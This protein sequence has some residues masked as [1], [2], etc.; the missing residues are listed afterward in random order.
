MGEVALTP[1]GQVLPNNSLPWLINMSIPNTSSTIA[2][3]DCFDAASDPRLIPASLYDCLHAAQQITQKGSLTRPITLTRRNTKRVFRLPQVFRSGTCI[4]SVDVDNDD[5]EDKFPI[6]TVHQAALDLSM[7]CVGGFYHNGG[8]IFVGPRKLLYV[9]VFGRTPPPAPT[10]EALVPAAPNA[11]RTIARD[12]GGNASSLLN[13]LSL[14]FSGSSILNTSSLNAT[15]HGACFDP[16]LSHE[17]RFPTTEQDCYKA[18]DILIEERLRNVESTFGRNAW[19][20]YKLP[21]S[22]RHG[23]CGIFVDVPNEDEED[24]F[25][26][27]KLYSATLELAHECAYGSHKYGGRIIMGPKNVVNAVTFGRVNLDEVQTATKSQAAHVIVRK[28]IESNVSGS[29]LQ[30]SFNLDGTTITDDLSFDERIDPNTSSLISN[31]SSLLNT[32]SLGGIPECYDP[33]LP[34]ERAYPIN[35][36]DCV[37]ATRQIVGD[38]QRTQAYTFSRKSIASPYYYHLPATFIYNSCVIVLD[39]A[40]NQD[41]DTVKV[42]YV[43]STAY[44]LAHKCSGEERP[45]ENF[46]GRVTVGVGANDLINVYVYGRLLRPI[47]EEQLSAPTQVASLLDSE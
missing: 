1:T 17:V 27:W 2:E 29:L 6:G 24:T 20:D 34:R 28:Q 47:N 23:T 32:S 10:D 45:E 35:F 33:P 9:T 7:R 14:D 26:L 12:S 46:G 31:G 36:E 44:V 39:M 11:H 38:R 43:E 40:N 15:I 42:I 22:A 19:H 25:E 4:I 41:Q 37:E 18:A 16:P 30:P 8:K 3:K 21:T 13:S 5:D